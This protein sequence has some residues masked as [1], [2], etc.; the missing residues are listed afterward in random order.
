M[1]QH[2]TPPEA[3]ALAFSQ[4]YAFGVIGTA[5]AELQDI[6]R[7]YGPMMHYGD[8]RDGDEDEAR[9]AEVAGACSVA[10]ARAMGRLLAGLAWT[11]TGKVQSADEATRLVE[12]LIGDVV[13][14]DVPDPDEIRRRARDERAE[15]EHR[16]YGRGE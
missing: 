1:N 13:L 4:R 6:Q 11:F 16:Q 9:S 10:V 7:R 2:V 3:T 14:A 12:E 8:P 5:I 15:G